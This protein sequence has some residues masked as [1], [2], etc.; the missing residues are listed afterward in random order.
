MLLAGLAV[1]SS[2]QPGAAATPRP[3][4]GPWPLGA[5]TIV[6]GGVNGCP[7]GFAC[8]RF[9]VS[10]CLDVRQTATAELAVAFPP[11]QTRGTVVFFTGGT[12]QSWW[13]SMTPAAEALLDRLRTRSGFTVVE[14]KW[15]L[16]WLAASSGEAAGPAHLACRPATAIQWIHDHVYVPRRVRPASG[17]C[18]FCVTGSS[19]GASQAAYALSHYGLDGILDGVFPTSGPPHAAL[20]KGCQPGY[21]G[22]QY[23]PDEVFIDASYGFLDPTHHPGPC[24]RQDPAWIPAWEADSVDT[25]ANDVSHPATRIEFVIGGQDVTSAPEHAADYHDLLEQDPG[26]DVTWTFVPSMVHDIQLSQD[27][28]AALEAAIVA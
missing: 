12:G 5:F 26:N 4:A 24:T 19:G 1:A 14:V 8:S 9:A 7:V 18:G 28:L 13:G 11:G 10:A 17:S 20:V 2:L 27:G 22:Y 16:P 21:P 15:M 6:P 25:G 3:S 23:G